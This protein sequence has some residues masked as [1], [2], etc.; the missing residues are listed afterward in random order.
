M[1]NACLC[2][3]PNFIDFVSYKGCKYTAYLMWAA[4]DTFGGQYFGKIVKNFCKNDCILSHGNP[5][6]RVLY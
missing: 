1:D 3:Y 6:E 4:V 2:E 5:N